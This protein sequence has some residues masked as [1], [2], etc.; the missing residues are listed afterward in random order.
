MLKR[1]SRRKTLF[2]SNWTFMTL[3]VF[4]KSFVDL[5]GDSFLKKERIKQ[6]LLYLGIGVFVLMVGFRLFISV[7]SIPG[8][9]ALKNYLMK[10]LV[11]AE[12]LPS[13]SSH[14]QPRES[15]L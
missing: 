10:E 2:Q 4:K 14:A 5:R 7:E 13:G 8:H 9:L 6:G 15:A 12:P 1:S 11:K 3:D